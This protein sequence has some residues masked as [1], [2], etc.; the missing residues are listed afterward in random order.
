MSKVF[1]ALQAVD[2]ARPIIEAIEEDNPNAEVDYQPAM[3]RISA[4]NQL[5]VNRESVEEILGREWEPSE[6]QLLLV[7]FGGNLESD[8]DQFTISWNN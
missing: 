8:E 3:V 6:I 1:L 2:E 7:T 4:D 5:T